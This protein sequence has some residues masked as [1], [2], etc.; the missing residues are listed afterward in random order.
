[1]KQVILTF[2]I[3]VT[4]IILFIVF[5]YKI[6]NKTITVK[7]L[8][9]NDYPADVAIFPIT[10]T[11]S[12]NN[13][14]QI[15]SDLSKD[16]DKI[17]KF[18]FDQGIEINELTLNPPRIQDTKTEVYQANQ[19]LDR[20]IAE[21][22]ITIYTQKVGLIQSLFPKLSKLGEEGVL[23]KMGYNQ[24]PEYLFTGLNEIK[25]K[26]LAIAIKNA[27]VTATNLTNQAKIKL[28]EIKS[29]NQGQFSIN[30][31]DSSNP[32]IKRIRV[33]TTVIYSIK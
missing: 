32:Q 29:I 28:G 18:L 26:M 20:F 1:M 30:S 13:L 24:S 16:K 31:R 5:S 23:L 27:N 4:V 10:F 3:C 33:V 19:N 12:N 2:F 22:T 11:R 14:S 25:Q 17:Q 21:Q 6:N 15:Y 9:E 8:A 7:G